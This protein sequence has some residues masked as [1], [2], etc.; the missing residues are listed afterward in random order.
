M[1]TIDANTSIRLSLVIPAL[2]AAV[3]IASAAGVALYQASSAASDVRTE[4]VR[5]VSVDHAHDLQLQRQTDA[6]EAM[7]G[8]LNEIKHEV[9]DWRREETERLERALRRERR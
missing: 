6:L 2:A 9:K 3:S 5:A 8:A 7:G 4:A 1:P